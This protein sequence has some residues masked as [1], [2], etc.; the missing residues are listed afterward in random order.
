MDESRSTSPPE[1]VFIII[2]GFLLGVALLVMAVDTVRVT[3]AE[4]QS[5]PVAAEVPDE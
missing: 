4:R 2:A 3:L 5:D 1:D